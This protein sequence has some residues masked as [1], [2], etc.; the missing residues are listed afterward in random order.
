VAPDAAFNKSRIYRKGISLSRGGEFIGRAILVAKSPA[1]RP[2]GLCWSGRLRSIYPE[3]L[4]KCGRK[5]E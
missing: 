3:Q 5:L 2:S 4:Q 1:G